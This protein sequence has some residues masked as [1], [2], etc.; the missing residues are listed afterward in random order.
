[1]HAC[2]SNI[3]FKLTRSAVAKNV[4]ANPL[5]GIGHSHDLTIHAEKIPQKIHHLGHRASFS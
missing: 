4:T 5:A 2:I 3:H 1:M